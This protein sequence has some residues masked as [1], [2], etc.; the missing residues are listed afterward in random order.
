MKSLSGSPV[1]RHTVFILA[2]GSF[3]VQWDESRVQ[4]LLNGRYRTYESDDFGHAITDYE[5]NQLKA[6]GRVEHYNR[7]YVWLFSL[8]E[9]ER[10]EHE[11][12]AHEHNQN[13]VRS[14][15]LN[16]TL[17]KSELAGIEKLLK[18]LDLD[19]DFL[20]RNRGDLVAILGKNG[21]PFRQLNDAERAQKLLL[22]RA[23]DM[24]KNTA[25]AF[26][27]TINSE[28]SYKRI[29]EQSSPSPDLAMIIA[30]QTDITVTQNKCA[31]LVM[32]DEEQRHAISDLMLDMQM[33]PE[34]VAT[35]A[36]AL[37]VIEDVKP[38]LLVMDLLLPDMHG[39][40]ML[41]KIKEIET[42]KYLPVIVIA[43]HSSPADNQAFALTVVKVDV[44]LVKPISMA[45]LR[46]NIWVTLKNKHLGE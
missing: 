2:D 40:E 16:T 31:V 7:Q 5:L 44:Y 35:G 12:K 36:E 21:A 22:A 11:A 27:E 13:R 9:V 25:I 18:N 37:Q 10:L 4:E 3:V 45:Q 30:S 19:T 41:A 43:D 32:G 6:A 1:P 17:P 46:Q 34:M 28:N 29:T 26:I 39:W 23:P 14:Y 8:P 42:L 33:R 24:F 15:Y 20:A 38:D